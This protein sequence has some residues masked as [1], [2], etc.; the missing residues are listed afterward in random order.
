M[1]CKFQK[2]CAGVGFRAGLS[3]L[4]NQREMLCNFPKVREGIGFRVGL[5]LF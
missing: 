5:S 1:L 4:V 2:V 3:F